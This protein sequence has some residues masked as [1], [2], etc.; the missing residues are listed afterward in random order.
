[1]PHAHITFD[2][3]ELAMDRL[4]G[5]RT[6]GRDESH[7]SLDNNP[8][9]P[10]PYG[11]LERLANSG[12]LRKGNLLVDYGCGKGRV[13]LFLSYQTRCQSLGVEWDQWLYE[14]AVRNQQHAVS[15]RRAQFVRDDACTFVPP[16]HA[17]RFYFFNPFSAEIFTQALAHINDA[18]TP[19][20]PGALVLLYYPDDTY[21]AVLEVT[22]NLRE[23][24]DCRD[25]F[26][27]C[28][29]RERIEIWEQRR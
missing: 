10:T 24:I 21:R 11:V 19:A 29:P 20:S 1:M 3:A 14:A 22:W 23:V 13:G 12:Y 16:A 7:A 4:L 8:Y 28:D 6:T 17:D 9:E 5:I 2:E 27:G 15:G 18:L 26:D 25:L